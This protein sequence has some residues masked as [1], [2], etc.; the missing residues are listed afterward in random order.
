M[1]TMSLKV[2]D[3]LYGDLTALAEDKGLSRAALVRQALADFFR[4]EKVPAKVSALAMLDDLVGSAE[5]PED[6][7]CNPDHLADLGQ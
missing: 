5:G 2:T 7:S 1:R 6:L 4:R 3:T